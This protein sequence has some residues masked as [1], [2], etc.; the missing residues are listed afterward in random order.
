MFIRKKVHIFYL[1]L[2]ANIAGFQMKNNVKVIN[3][4]DTNG[5]CNCHSKMNR[6]V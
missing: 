3:Q 5:G 6:I 2:A 1:H 4:F